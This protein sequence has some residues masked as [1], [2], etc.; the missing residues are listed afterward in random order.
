MGHENFHESYKFV[1][2]LRS[3]VA[4][5]VSHYNWSHQ[6]P[7]AHARIDESFDA[8]LDTERA[9]R[10]GATYVEYYC[11]LSKETDLRSDIAIEAA[12][13]N[14]K[15]FSVVGDLADI[16]AFER[17]LKRE[18]GVRVNVKHENKGGSDRKFVSLSSLSAATLQKV[19]DLCA[20]DIAVW[21]SFIAEKAN[22]S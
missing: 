16:P 17:D 11:G 5:F 2:I 12:I 20:P 1:T 9:K 6:K 8:F 15:K 4:R 10:L 18:L 3:P 22:N 19:H 13:E 21:E 14:L 7:A